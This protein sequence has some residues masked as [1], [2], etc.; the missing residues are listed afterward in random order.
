MV[1]R[2]QACS[3]RH[4]LAD[5][6][7]GSRTNPS[8]CRKIKYSNRSVTSRSSPTSDHRWSATP[9]DFWHPAGI[10]DDQRPRGVT[11]ELVTWEPAVVAH[12][13]DLEDQLPFCA[14]GS[15]CEAAGE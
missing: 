9:P 12:A 7:H 10:H 14:S 6:R 2:M 4:L 3:C 8:T 15:A 11:Q 1:Q 13:R 5:V